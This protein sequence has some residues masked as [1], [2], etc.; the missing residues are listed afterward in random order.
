MVCGAHSD[1]SDRALPALVAGIALIYNFLF[2][3][4]A[5]YLPDDPLYVGL[6]VQGY[7]FAGC[8]LSLLGV[9]GV[10]TVSN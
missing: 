3:A 2:A 9:I 10:A 8:I 4:I 1:R 6:S 7:A 5:E